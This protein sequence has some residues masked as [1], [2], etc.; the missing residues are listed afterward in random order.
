M[1]RPAVSG[2]GRAHGLTVDRKES[3]LELTQVLT[4]PG[5]YEA[6]KL[7]R[8]DAVEGV[9]DNRFGR[10]GERTK[11]QLST[12]LKGEPLTEISYRLEAICT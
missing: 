12:S 5:S 10:H 11:S 6:I 2:A 8:I 3:S 7:I 1:R 4:N 9:P